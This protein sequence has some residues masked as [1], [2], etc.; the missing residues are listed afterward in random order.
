MD[1]KERLK[2]SWTSIKAFIDKGIIQRISRITYD[3]IWNIILFLIVIGLVGAFFVGGVGAGYF[4]SLVKDEPLRAEED[5]VNAVYN[6]SETSEIYFANNVYMGEVSADLHREEVELNQIS[7]YLI[8]AIIATEDEYFE[9]HNGIVPKA[10]LRALYQE[11]SGS[12]TQT[13]GSTLT[14]QIIKNQILTNEVS[15]D[16]KAKEIVLAMRLEHFLE[17]DELLEA[18]LN[19]VPFGR[20]ANGRNVAGAQ[21]AAQ[22]I[23]GVDADELSL[24]QAAYIAGLPQSPM[25]YTPFTSNGA[26]KSE[27]AL[28]PGLNRKQIVLSRM[29]ESEY[30]DE[31]EY[32]EALAYDIVQDFT[33]RTPSTH[34]Q[35][36]YLTE[37]VRRR[38][39]EILKVQ[40]AIDDGYTEED[41]ESSEDLQ[42]QYQI[43]AN[44]EL[45]QGGYSIHTT[46]DKDIYDAFQEVAANYG[47]YGRDKT[48]RNDQ[49]QA[50][51]TEDP[52]TGE[53]V[54]LVTP[55]QAGTVLIENS[56]GAIISFV[57]GRDFERSQ[58]NFATNAP[59]QMG[60][61]A[62]PLLV[63]APAMEE[64]I[65]QPGSV[66]ADVRIEIPQPGREDWV[67]SN[68]T[69]NRYYGLVS[70][71]TAVIDS[72]NVSAVSVYMDLLENHNPVPDY[73]MQMG[74]DNID[75]VAY[76]Y[77]SNALGSFAT[78]V[79]G[80][81]NGYATFGNGG[82][83]AKGYMIEKIETNTGETIY[84]H[85]V[86]PVEVFSPE[87]NYLMIDMMRDVLSSGT[88]R[89]A[90]NNLSNPN[91]DWAGKTGTTNEFRDTWFVAT[92]PNVTIGSWMGYEYNQQLDDG[93]S[94]RNQ[95]F[96]AELVNVA[97]E[98]NPDLMAPT[99]NFQ[100]PN[101]IVSQS[102][103]LT[104]GLIPS[105]ICE[106]LSL[107]GN[108]I[109]NT[110]YLPDE[111]DYSL[112]E[113]RYVL[114][115]GEA[116]VAG[117]QTPEEFVLT[118][119]VVFNPDWLE[120]MGYDQLED[121]SQLVPSSNPTWSSIEIPSLTKVE[122]DE[123]PP[124]VPQ[125][126]NKS[127]NVLTWEESSSHDVV[128]Y[129]VYRANEP[130]SSFEHL[131]STTDTNL[132]VGNDEGVFYVTAVDYFGEESEPS[133]YLIEGDFT[134]EEEETEED[135]DEDE[136]VEDREENED[137]SDDE[138][139]DDAQQVNNQAN[140]ANVE[141]ERRNRGNSRNQNSND[142]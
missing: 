65:I 36:P 88:G 61:T 19:I 23:F 70:A 114:L 92:N 69:R 122:D 76:G 6:Y 47:N 51:M 130:E 45:S 115:N 28:Q 86:D 21:T 94:A 91:I 54:P 124:N 103:C 40:L 14:Q 95:A 60:S 24:A 49:G 113:G 141:D 77:E 90:R 120:D 109:Y 118:D 98:I 58:R 27:E 104:S 71:R 48:A 52:E 116:V 8:H 50:I 55:V 29:L 121:L 18:Y 85:E 110:A 10:I 140:S 31:E 93:Y 44:R 72:Y 38:A 15:F 74:F 87:T 101:N 7:D 22:G 102:Y 97:T 83:F 129:R 20:N 9:T 63:Y 112:I 11:V 34:E 100:R 142:N 133:D 30:I 82:E 119:G 57:G 2:K 131:D 106:S 75:P 67:P 99:D 81:T 41:L 33:E 66:I 79:E 137:S 42:E 123:R 125:H 56:T 89:T 16:R 35:Y 135:T 5:M 46:I 117:E 134:P 138:E 78:T 136:Q 128:G 107:V 43:L 3:V 73:F 64:G 53:E 13:G 26:L 84:Q 132:N 96:W 25:A 139:T 17:K 39:N 62:K 12:A 127:G 4:A 111:A 32:E 59:R 105:D 37:E 126:I 68:F 108:D 80:N 1:F